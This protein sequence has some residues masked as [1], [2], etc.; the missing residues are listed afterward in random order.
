[1]AISSIGVG[2]GLPIDELLSDLR[3]SENHA[4]NLIQARQDKAEDRLSAYGK[5][6]SALSS[7]DAAAKTL[8]NPDT[9]GAFKTTSSSDAF[10]ANAAPGAMAGQYA[11]RVDQLAS[12]QSL[13]AQ[14][15]ADR[16]A[17][18]GS[19]GQITINLQNGQSTT[20]DLSS[21]GGTSLTDIAEAINGNADAGVNAT[22]INDGDANAPFR[23]LLT[24]RETGTAASVQSLSVEDNTELSDLLTFSVDGDGAVSGSLTHEA[25]LDARLNING[26][27]ITN[28]SNTV[29]DVIEGV[30][31]TLEDTTPEN[32]PGSLSVTEDA[33]ATTKAIKD[34]VKAYNTLQD[35]LRSLTSYDIENNKA[36]ALTGDS[37]AR[38]LQ[39]DIRATLNVFG[40]GE[41]VRTLGQLGLT[42]DTRTGQLE[43]DETKLADA[44]KNNPAEVQ[45]LFSGT[46]GVGGRVSQVAETFTRSGGLFSI[47]TDSINRSITDIQRQY[48]VTSERIDNRMEGY[49]RQ[50]QQLDRMMAEMSSVSDYLTQQLAMLNNLATGNKG[51]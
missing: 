34:F 33:S 19:G 51:N 37:L 24:S 25:A 5:L 11:I 44:L 6:K 27:D 38:R 48:E 31:L 3:K 18:I 50:F 4:L 35:S 8:D 30:T 12:H 45:S 22:I 28:G 42:T 14:G 49:R 16:S 36:S 13:V 9:Y 43:L 47:S 29:E 2:S 26:I 40:G 1:M 32:A 46:T 7:L 21:A 15:V 41:N 17:N 23:L 10:S 20:I 39:G